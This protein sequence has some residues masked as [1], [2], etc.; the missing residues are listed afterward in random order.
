VPHPGHHDEPE[1]RWS[2]SSASP[3]DN[4]S[5]ITWLHP[6]RRAARLAAAIGVVLGVLCIVLGTLALVVELGPRSPA[7]P[8]LTAHGPGEHSGSG[9]GQPQSFQVRGPG[10][11]DIAWSFSCPRGQTGFKMADSRSAISSN[12]GVNWPGAHGSGLW[13]DLRDGGHRVVIITMCSWHARVFGPTSTPGPSRSDQPQQATPAAHTQAKQH[14]NDKHRH[15][16]K[17]H[18]HRQKHSPARAGGD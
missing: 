4:V 17:A 12:P 16:K 13:L 14:G 3:G 6:R 9:N 8:R 1:D 11:H 7:K 15:K 18:H 5:R 10:P 2:D